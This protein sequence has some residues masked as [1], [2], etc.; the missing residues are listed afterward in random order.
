MFILYGTLTC[1]SVPNKPLFLISLRFS[2][3]S[4]LVFHTCCQHATGIPQSCC[5]RIS[6]AVKRHHDHGNSY[7][8][9]HLAGAGLHLQRFCQLSSWQEAWR[10][11]GRYGAG[12]EAENSTSRLAGSQKG[13]PHWVCT[14]HLRPQSL[15]QF[16]E[17][18][19]SY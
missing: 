15:S 16:H 3:Y 4:L 18:H 11:T 12:I 17:G 8:G 9:K 13:M 10:H 5:L 7:K 14:E 19:T 1:F 6:I 2:I